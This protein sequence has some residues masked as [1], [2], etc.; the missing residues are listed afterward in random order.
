MNILT[1]LVNRSGK[2]ALSALQ[3]V[4]LT[5]VVGVAGVAAYQFLG[6][7]ADDN[8]AFNPAGQYNPGEIVYVSGANTGN[9]VGNAYGG[10]LERSTGE[11]GSTMQVSTKTLKL[12]ENQE[13]AE[14]AAQELAENEREMSLSQVNTPAYQLGQTEGLGMGANVANEQNLAGSPMGAMSGVMG[15][16]MANIQNMM[17]SAQQQAQA[18]AGKA[19]KDAQAAQGGK[20]T[21][22]LASATP[23]W[24]SG[25][26]SA[27]GG[28]SNGGGSSFVVQNSGKNAPKG[29]DMT[30][31]MGVLANAQNVMNS[32]K[33]GSQIKAKASFGN[34]SGMGKSK[35]ATVMG[36]RNSQQG[37]DDLK[38][39]QKRSAE[40][41]ANK[42]RHNTEANVFLAG[43]QISGGIMIS[44]DHVNLGDVKGS[45]DLSTNVDTQLSGMQ[46]GIES[47][48]TPVI[49]DQGNDQNKLL[50]AI[51]GG[52]IVAFALMVVISYFAKSGWPL[53][54]IAIAA[55]L[56][57][58]AEAWLMGKWVSDYVE[59]W[60]KDG[61][62]LAC[63]IAP[64]VWI[65]G[66][67]LSWI[68]P[69]A[70]QDAWAWIKKYVLHISTEAAAEGGGTAAAGGAV[71]GGGESG[72]G[73][74]SV[75][76]EKLKFLNPF[77]D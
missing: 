21:P 6:T 1:K 14:R 30:A 76:T 28:A 29:G 40:V 43:T 45:K 4:G 49:E 70:F 32:M 63:T 18:A 37:K 46:S 51:I 48:V 12:L 52:S 8:M 62:S 11:P 34:S 57:I 22:T 33:E 13:M 27:G 16:Q 73:M 10:K 7:S 26:S 15:Q 75:F 19:E 77:I 35:D 50:L 24:R 59:K 47:E 56:A 44:A 71:T 53:V 54:L 61:W 42:N 72:S 67:A 25:S 5:A 2:M 69:K 55:S 38:F 31:A 20:G 58:L 66:G 64:L 3:A 65:A 39:F 23:N 74:F 41:A 17:S 60:G 68:H 9:Y 36:G